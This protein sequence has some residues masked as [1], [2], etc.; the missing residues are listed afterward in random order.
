M[1]LGLR[2]MMG[3]AHLG[4][5]KVESSLFEMG[6]KIG[7]NKEQAKYVCDGPRSNNWQGD[8]LDGTPTKRER[9]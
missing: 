9:H 7:L 4:C 3:L 6:V 8:R 2:L 5:A 1:P